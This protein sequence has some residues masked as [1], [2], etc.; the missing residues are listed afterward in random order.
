MIKLIVSDLDETLLGLDGGISDENIEAIKKAQKAGVKFVP[1]TGRGFSSVQG[2]LQKL[3]LKDKK[4]EF[5]ISY[6]GGAIVENAGLKIVQTNELTFEQAS[7]IYDIA[8]KVKDFD[9]HV[10][11]INDVYIYNPIQADLDYIETRGVKPIEYKNR[12]L[13]SLRDEKI[14]K[15]ITMNSDFNR[16]AYMKDLVLKNVDFDLNVTFSSDRY[17]EFN[18]KGVDKGLATLELANHLGIKKDE[19]MAIG[20]N[21]NDLPMLSKVGLPIAVSNA[22]DQAKEIAKHVTNGNY[23]N[24]VA[25]AINKFVLE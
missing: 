24:G 7:E 9:T 2:L 18:K 15:V 11:T 20:D 13:E 19:I 12:N 14:M 5:V 8:T 21:G 6:N 16:L 4:E 3:G 17:T 10:Y 23:I 1:N 22:N 25:E